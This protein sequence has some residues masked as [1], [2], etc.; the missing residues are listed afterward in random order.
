MSTNF[1]VSTTELSELQ[2]DLGVVDYT[3][4]EY[5]NQ[6]LAKEGLPQIGGFIF[7]PG[8]K[9]PPF[10][11]RKPERSSKPMEPLAEEQLRRERLGE[12][13][14]PVW[15]EARPFA[16]RRVRLKSKG[17]KLSEK[18]T[19]LELGYERYIILDSERPAIVEGPDGAYL[20]QTDRRKHSC[21]DMDSDQ[22]HPSTS[23]SGF[24]AIPVP[25]APY[26]ST[27]QE[28]FERRLSDHEAKLGL[29]QM[30]FVGGHAVGCL[31]VR[32]KRTAAK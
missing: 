32:G 26:R 3:S 24:A 15:G 8:R 31:R 19:L 21:P 30:Y 10:K 27:G 20:H 14:G 4:R 2:L 6:L 11:P 12:S 18:R 22:D 23:A 5:W 28:A 1:V 25:H 17:F 16:A 9:L 13:I 7:R 29:E